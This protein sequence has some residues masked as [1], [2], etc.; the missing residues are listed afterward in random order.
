MTANGVP[1]VT[2]RMNRI[3]SLYGDGR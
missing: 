3:A 1:S 2:Y